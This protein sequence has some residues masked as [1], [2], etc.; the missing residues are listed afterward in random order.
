MPRNKAVDLILFAGQSNMAGRGNAID[1]P[2]CPQEAGL[3]Y[4]A[5]SAPERLFPIA[6][7][8][9]LHENVPGQIDDDAKKS[10][11]LV[12]AFVARYHQLTGRTVIAV[13]A[14]EGGT[15]TQQWLDGLASDAASR[16][17][18]ARGFLES[19]GF[20]LQNIFVL[21]CQGETDGDYAVS[22]A[23]YIQNFGRIWQMFRAAGAQCCGLIQ[24]G[25]YNQSV[26]PEG[27]Y[28]ISG[29]VLDAQYGVIRDAQRKIVSSDTDV[30]SA[31]SFAPYE[32]QMKD[33]FHYRQCAYN[34]VGEEA[35]EK[36][37]AYLPCEQIVVNCLQ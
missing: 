4:R 29:T 6:E 21:W 18:Q 33:Q 11:S 3:E 37:A 17:A 26:Y 9:G 23:Q 34:E 20:V 19:S 1:A 30:F 31:G 25:H 36:C 35:A 10:G 8:F 22:A 2:Y 7:P 28:G 13:S 24:I 12:S 27:R 32:G 5:I 15:S 14:S 16:L